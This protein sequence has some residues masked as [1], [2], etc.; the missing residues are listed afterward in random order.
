MRFIQSVVFA[1]L[2]LA[3]GACVINIGDSESASAA[4]SASTAEGVSTA[5]G[6]SG[7][8]AEGS[9]GSSGATAEGS[10]GSSTEGSSGSPTEGSSTAVDTT[11]GSGTTGAVGGACGWVEAQ[12]IYACGGMGEDPDGI[13]PIDC[14]EP[15]VEGAPCDGDRGPIADPGCC[16]EGVNAYCYLGKLVVTICR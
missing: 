12:N 2:P 16:S 15:P 10:S 7:S 11:E 3:S 13:I 5:E 4:E 6:S 14:A 8:T 9:S 1:V